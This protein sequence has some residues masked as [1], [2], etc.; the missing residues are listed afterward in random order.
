[1]RGHDVKLGEMPFNCFREAPIGQN[2]P[3]AVFWGLKKLR[4]GRA[5]GIATSADRAVRPAGDG[6]DAD[7]SSLSS[8]SSIVA[9]ICSTLPSPGSS[10]SSSSAFFLMTTRLCSIVFEAAQ[11]AQHAAPVP[12]ESLSYPTIGCVTQFVL[13]WRIWH[14]RSTRRRRIVRNHQKRDSPGDLRLA[15]SQWPHWTCARASRCRGSGFRKNQK[16]FCRA[17]STAQRCLWAPVASGRFF[18]MGDPVTARCFLGTCPFADPYPISEIKSGG[19]QDIKPNPISKAR[20]RRLP[21]LS[22]SASIDAQ[23]AQVPLRLFLASD[24][25]RSCTGIC[26]A[27]SAKTQVHQLSPIPV[28]VLIRYGPTY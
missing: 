2:W 4:A 13:D 17:S 16:S 12:Q 1:M 10:N 18:P 15:G 7:S 25:S 14:A 28:D 24:H 20:G 5:P 22:R 19:C 21:R 26:F 23:N 27:N 11:Q 8:S 3:G 9:A 6:P